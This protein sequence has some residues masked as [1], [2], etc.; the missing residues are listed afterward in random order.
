MLLLLLQKNIN[1]L[2]VLS[3]FSCVLNSIARQKHTH[4]FYF[5][6]MT[7]LFFQRKLLSFLT[8]YDKGYSNNDSLT[9][10]GKILMSDDTFWCS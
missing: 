5:F 8:S 3:L 4:D 6:W 2:H 9:T 10:V 7:W 1:V